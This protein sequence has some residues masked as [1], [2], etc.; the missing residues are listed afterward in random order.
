[1]RSALRFEPLLPPLPPLYQAP[2][3]H[4]DEVCLSF[5]TSLVPEKVTHNFSVEFVWNPTSFKRMQ[6]AMRAFAVDETCVSGYIY[7]RL[8]GHDL[9][10]QTLKVTLPKRFE[11][12]AIY[13]KPSPSVSVLSF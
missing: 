9:E 1:M 8:L 13:W 5:S 12:G 4:N 6:L 10:P 3:S 11:A 7:H 2:D